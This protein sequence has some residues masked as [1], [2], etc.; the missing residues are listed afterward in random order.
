MKNK[1]IPTLIGIHCSSIIQE[2]QIISQISINFQNDDLQYF[3]Q[4]CT[5]IGTEEGID[6]AVVMIEN[7]ISDHALVKTY[8]MYVPVKDY[9][10][11]IRLCEINLDEMKMETNRRLNITVEKLINSLGNLLFILNNIF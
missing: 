3:D 11:I 9:E 1:Y 10:K 4:I 6:L 2:I 5:I 8:E 7:V